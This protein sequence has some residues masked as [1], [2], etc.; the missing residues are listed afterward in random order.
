M[1]TSNNAPK[2]VKQ[3]LCTG[4]QVLREFKAEIPYFNSNTRIN[5]AIQRHKDNEKYKALIIRLTGKSYLSGFKIQK[6]RY[7]YDKSNNKIEF[8]EGR[9]KQEKAANCKECAVLIYNRLAKR[10]QEPK[11][12]KLDIVSSEENI[13]PKNHT[14]TVIGMD[15]NADISR[16]HTWGK[17][18]VIVDG[19]ANIVQKSQE[20]IEYLKQLFNVNPEKEK[21]IFK[22]YPNQ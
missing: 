2:I 4:E 10:G 8:L 3:N 5:T 9:I 21:C 17:N 7:D 12:I 16:P 20:G 14:F 13:K 19:W 11:N 15:K 6:L 22:D 1:I 18:S